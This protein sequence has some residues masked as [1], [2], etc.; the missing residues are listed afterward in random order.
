MP[1]Q[2]K[3]CWA[4]LRHWEEARKNRQ[5]FDAKF[6]TQGWLISRRTFFGSRPSG[7][8]ASGRAAR[9]HPLLRVRLAELFLLL[10]ELLELQQLWLPLGAEAVDGGCQRRQRRL[11]VEERH[12]VDQTDAITD[13]KGIGGILWKPRLNRTEDYW[14]ELK[15]VSL[16]TEGR[17]SA[18]L[19]LT[20]PE[21]NK[22]SS[23]EILY[24][25]NVSPAWPNQSGP[26]LPAFTIQA[27]EEKS[28]TKSMSLWTR[29]YT[30]C[31]HHSELFYLVDRHP[32]VGEV[33]LLVLHQLDH[34]RLEAAWNKK[35]NGKE[36]IRVFQQ[37]CRKIEKE[38]R[39]F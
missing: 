20:L 3:L 32:V 7:R 36:S 5:T 10:L 14:S 25:I 24:Y 22:F 38:I 9:A 2:R 26:A 27:R 21:R 11:G 23:A 18:L 16:G 34:E 30:D 35:S 8:A 19:A 12:W 6:L 4:K 33:V 28:I 39:P 13:L 37:R 15:M 31:Q 29:I 17:K 1:S